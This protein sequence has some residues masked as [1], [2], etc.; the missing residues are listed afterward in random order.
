MLKTWFFLAAHGKCE[1]G[2]LNAAFADRLQA[3]PEMARVHPRGGAD[4]AEI[5]VVV[6]EKFFGD[7][8]VAQGSA[9]PF[10]QSPR[11]HRA[12]QFFFR[13]SLNLILSN[14]TRKHC[15]GPLC[16]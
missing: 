1:F 6:K 7:A 10:F 2:L 15:R 3:L 11:D 4:G 12:P 14:P 8:A 13:R 9:D 16:F 5:P